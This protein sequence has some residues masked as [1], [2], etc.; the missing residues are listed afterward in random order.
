[1]TGEELSL[2][3][4]NSPIPGHDASIERADSPDYLA[5]WQ[6]I[7]NSY[8]ARPA[9]AFDHYHD[10]EAYPQL[11]DAISEALDMADVTW[12]ISGHAAMQ[13]DV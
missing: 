7:L 13:Y 11:E 1:M 10:P 6:K 2:P 5:V 8:K 12:N 9:R 3:I 4:S